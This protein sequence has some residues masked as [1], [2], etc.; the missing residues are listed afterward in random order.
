MEESNVQP[1]RCPV[2]VCGDIH[3]QFVR[4]TLVPPHMLGN[5]PT[6]PPRVSLPP[7]RDIFSTIYRSSSASAVTHQIPITSSWVIT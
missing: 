2:T 1:V 7:L 4:P 5:S 6:E 3:G